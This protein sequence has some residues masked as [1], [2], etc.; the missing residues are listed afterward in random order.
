MNRI[1]YYWFYLFS[2][3]FS[4]RNGDEPVPLVQVGEKILYEHQLRELLPLNLTKADSSLWAE[5]YITKWVR[6]QLF[7]QQ[8]EANL[9]ELQK[10]VHEE[11]EEYRQSLVSFRYKN[12]MVNQKMDT[13]VTH[14]Q[15]MNYYEEH[16]D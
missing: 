3:V 8:A 16:K 1:K 7:V 6:K 4:C 14:D 15:I 11:L 10:D 2:L 13:V 5:D 9:T 12:E